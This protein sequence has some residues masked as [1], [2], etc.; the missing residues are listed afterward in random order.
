MG[1]LDSQGA[2]LFG[3]E[4]PKLKLP[5]DTDLSA[6]SPHHTLGRGVT[7]AAPGSHDSYHQAF[8]D[9]RYVLKAGDTM[10]GDLK[11]I[12][13]GGA[14]QSQVQL[15]ADPTVAASLKLE[16]SDGKGRWSVYK[17]SGA[18]T[19]S[20][21][22]SDFGIGAY[23]DDGSWLNSWMVLRR[24]D[25]YATFRNVLECNG[26]NFT[27]AINLP[28][29]T[30]LNTFRGSGF[31]DASGFIGTPFY[32]ST[33]D[34]S[35]Y[36]LVQIEHSNSSPSTILWK[37][38][39]LIGLNVSSSQP[40]TYERHLYNGVWTAW[41][42]MGQVLNYS[43]V[44]ESG[45]TAYGGN[46]GDDIARVSKH[47]QIVTVW[48][49][50]KR[51]SNLSISAGGTYGVCTLPSSGWYPIDEIMTAGI[52]THTGGSNLPVRMTL[53]KLDGKITFQSL[54]TATMSTGQWVGFNFSYQ[55]N[56]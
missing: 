2:P 24:A 32:P 48:G 12:N 56:I 51:T 29:G 17:G 54:H 47:G 41:Q 28:Y 18:E 16:N 1:L 50:A 40:V 35:W 7:Q 39:T 55:S 27:E 34:P 11:L 14:S 8:N 23:A 19:G 45:W 43:C 6:D 5:G 9:G 15:R 4:Y 37:K 52:Y 30:N 22:G 25:G 42:F 53:G 31:F 3:G 44:A 26:I 46:W 36:Y 33:S 21:A 38:Q 13:N 20:N 49:L 10:T